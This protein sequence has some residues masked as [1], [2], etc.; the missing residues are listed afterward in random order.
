MLKLRAPNL[1]QLGTALSQKA[2][3]G[4]NRVTS[5]LVSSNPHGPILKAIERSPGVTQDNECSGKSPGRHQ[6]P[7]LRLHHSRNYLF[8]KDYEYKWSLLHI[9]NT[10]SSDYKHW[11]EK[12]NDKQTYLFSFPVDILNH[13]F[14]AQLRAASVRSSVPPSAAPFAFECFGAQQQASAP[15]VPAWICC[16][17]CTSTNPFFCICKKPQFQVGILFSMLWHHTKGTVIKH[18][19]ILIL[20]PDLHLSPSLPGLL[21]TACAVQKSLSRWN[22]LSTVPWSTPLNEPITI[23]AGGVLPIN[24]MAQ[25]KFLRAGENRER[26]KDRQRSGRDNN[27]ECERERERWRRRSMK[28][29]HHLRPLPDCAQTDFTF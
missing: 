16:R 26:K 4:L 9:M 11:I 21:F 28:R 1:V 29:G 5:P 19:E 17:T 10:V 2:E 22:P 12:T 6:P 20:N 27:E 3:R 13:F 18:H 8:C 23:L 7:E 24:E 15:T 14:P 25:G